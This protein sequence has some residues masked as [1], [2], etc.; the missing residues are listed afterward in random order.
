LTAS[1]AAR[2]LGLSSERVRQLAR[3]GRLKGHDTPLGRLYDRDDVEALKRERELSRAAR[4]DRDL[5][6][7]TAP[8]ESR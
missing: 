7:A 3:Q 6:D 4:P 5:K 8:E 1:Q 2:L